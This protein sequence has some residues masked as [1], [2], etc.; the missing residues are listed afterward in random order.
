MLNEVEEYFG[1]NYHLNGLT[2]EAI[3]QRHEEHKA[4]FRSKGEAL[5]KDLEYLADVYKRSE[6]E[7]ANDFFHKLR[8]IY[9]RIC[10]L[11]DS[12]EAALYYVKRL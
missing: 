7:N 10:A 3:S 4:E 5:K 1:K 9:G 2:D 8:L 12:G 6:D 11:I